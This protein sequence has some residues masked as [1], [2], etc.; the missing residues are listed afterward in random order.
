MLLVLLVLLLLLLLLELLLLLFFLLLLLLRL[1][2]RLFLTRFHIGLMLRRVLLLLLEALGLVGAFLRLLLALAPRIIQLLLVI[3]LLLVVRRLVRVALRLLAL[4]LRL[5]QRV[6]ALFFLVRLLVR[7]ALRGFRFALR[8]ID[9]VLLL[10]LLVRLRACRFI[11][12]ALR[13]VGLVLC[14]LQRGLLVA[15]LRMGGALVVV[16][17]QLLAP[18]VCL[19]H[20]HLVARLAETVIHEE[21]AIAVVL[22]DCIAVVILGGAA[23]QHLLPCVEIALRPRCAGCSGHTCIGRRK[24]RSGIGRIAGLR[25]RRRGARALRLLRPG[26]RQRLR[27]GRNACPHA[28]CDGTNRPEGGEPPGGAN[29]RAIPGKG[30]IGGEAGGRQRLLWAA[31]HG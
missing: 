22:R 12:G 25:S 18:N 27:E 2:G 13:C 20:A 24:R 21:R 31:E 26:R 30:Q 16:E 4:A 9:R 5:G 14:A 19:D 17:R 11:G 3:R 10:L 15:L 8:L 29:G 6:L 7:R 23:V 28:Q 1:L